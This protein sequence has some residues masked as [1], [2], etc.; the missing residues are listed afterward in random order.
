MKGIVIR[1]G[2]FSKLSFSRKL[3]TI[4]LPIN[5]IADRLLRDS[6]P[7][8]PVFGLTCDADSAEL[9]YRAVVQAR[10]SHGPWG[11]CLHLYDPSEYASMRLF[12]D[13][14]LRSGFAL[15]GSEV[16]SVFSHR[17]RRERHASQN[18]MAVATSIGGVRLS[19][20]DTV[21]PGLYER[22]GFRAVARL[23]WDEDLAPSDWDYLAT[24]KFNDGRPDVV[25]MSHTTTVIPEIQVGTYADGLG[26]Q[27]KSFGGEV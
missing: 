9:F 20:F 2:C 19:A 21:L 8:F 4:H 12:V 18:L 16:V 10:Q 17:D 25:F 3:G 23:A 22:C 13:A 11:A 15:K 27:L 6:L 1:P 26:Y 14:E 24:R 7:V 5:Q